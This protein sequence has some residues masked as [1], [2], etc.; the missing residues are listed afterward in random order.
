[1]EET[2]WYL[3]LNSTL[4]TLVWPHSVMVCERGAAGS[5]LAPVSTFVLSG[6]EK[7]SGVRILDDS[8]GVQLGLDLQEL[9]GAPTEFPVHVVDVEAVADRTPRHGLEYGAV[10]VAVFERPSVDA[11]VTLFVDAAGTEPGID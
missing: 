3:N 7:F 9:I 1:M 5:T 2:L 4:S 11:G 8:G 6:A 10:E